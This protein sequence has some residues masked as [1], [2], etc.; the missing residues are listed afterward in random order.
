MGRL[1]IFSYDATEAFKDSYRKQNEHDFEERT[2]WNAIEEIPG[3]AVFAKPVKSTLLVDG[4]YMSDYQ[5]IADMIQKQFEGL[6]YV[7]GTIARTNKGEDMYD[8][9]SNPD[10]DE[11]FTNYVL[12]RD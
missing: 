11:E 10:S 8:E 7:I 1:I 2:L 6:S 4:D 3:I 5:K 12:E 9:E